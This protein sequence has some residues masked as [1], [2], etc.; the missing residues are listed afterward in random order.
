VLHARL[1]KGLCIR[2]EGGSGDFNSRAML[3]TC[4][5][6]EVWWKDDGLVLVMRCCRY[7]NGWRWM[8]L[9]LEACPYHLLYHQHSC[10]P[11]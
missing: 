10:H 4:S 1:R 8:A 3:G 5:R 11:S 9:A 6:S 2:E 7:D